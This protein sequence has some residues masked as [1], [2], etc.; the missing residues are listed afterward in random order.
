MNQLPTARTPGG[1]EGVRGP[2]QATACRPR[3]RR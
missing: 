3:E 2:M 1:D